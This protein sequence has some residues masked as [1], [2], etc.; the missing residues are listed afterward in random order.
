MCYT[1][2]IKLKHNHKNDSYLYMYAQTE[3][4]T[5]SHPIMEYT[6][7]EYRQWLNSINHPHVVKKNEFSPYLLKRFEAYHKN[8][9]F[10]TIKG[11][12]FEVRKRQQGIYTNGEFYDWLNSGKI[13][14]VKCNDNDYPKENS[15]LNRRLYKL[16]LEYQLLHGKKL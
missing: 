10:E 5:I 8:K 1:H 3:N 4:K 16:F 9:I 6:H 7:Q 2:T 14:Y 11:S 15:L 12:G 13:R